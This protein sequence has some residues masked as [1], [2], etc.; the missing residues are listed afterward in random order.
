M[1][2]GKDLSNKKKK[3]KRKTS[4]ASSLVGTSIQNN[5]GSLSAK[6]RVWTSREGLAHANMTLGTDPGAGPCLQEGTRA[7]SQSAPHPPT[8]TRKQG[9]LNGRNEGDVGRLVG[10]QGSSHPLSLEHTGLQTLCGVLRRQRALAENFLRPI[11]LPF[12][13]APSGKCYNRVPSTL[14]VGGSHFSRWLCA[15]PHGGHWSSEHQNPPSWE[16]LRPHT[17]LGHSVLGK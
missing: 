14:C 11:S 15:P 9:S 2:V 6:H 7:H 1:G 8:M 13:A 10:S 4:S 16:F 3:K 12:A 17:P 5:Q